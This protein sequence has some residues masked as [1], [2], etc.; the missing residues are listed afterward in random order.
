MYCQK[1]GSKMEGTCC[2]RC[3]F[4]LA[5]NIQTKTPVYNQNVNPVSDNGG[6]GL[7]ILGFCFPMVGL[8]LY[9]VW[10]D[11]K[12]ISAHAA[13]KGALISF[14]GGIIMYAIYFAIIFITVAT[15]AY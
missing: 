13:G 3:G 5:T 10:K 1:C 8:I 7:C 9:L 15:V 14:V 11:E 4:N 2:T 12:P 6:F